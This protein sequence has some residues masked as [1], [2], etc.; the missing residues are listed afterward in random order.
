MTGCAAGGM[1]CASAVSIGG[2]ASS[3]G[4]G[5]YGGRKKLPKSRRPPIPGP[6]PRPIEKFA[7]IGTLRVHLKDSRV[8]TPTTAVAHWFAS[9]LGMLTKQIEKYDMSEFLEK[10]SRFLSETRLRNVLLVDIDYDRVYEDKSPDDLKNAI[11]ATKRYISQ[12]KGG[13]NKVLI[14]ALGKTDRDPKKDLH[15]TVEMQ[16][17]RKHGLG[18]PGLEVKITGIPSVLLPR[19]KETKRQYE[20]RQANLATRLGGGR[21]R[22][23][24]RKECENTMALVLRDYE[25]H[26]KGAFE[27]DNVERMDT[28]L[29]KNIVPGRP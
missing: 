7:L 29:E 2:F 26:L 1:H 5:A 16:Y 20:A 9:S 6:E 11:L 28:I 4:S 25:V 14:S 12:N 22:A 17:Y 19:K 18:K 13:G 3:G 23:G 15:L 27:T 24:F 21:R 10:A 8:S